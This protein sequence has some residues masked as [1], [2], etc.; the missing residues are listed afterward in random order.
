MLSLNFS[1]QKLFRWFRRP[2][3]WATSDWQLHHK[4]VLA[5]VYRHVQFFGETSNHPG[6]S[7]P[8]YPRLGI[9]WSGF[10]KNKIIFEREEISDHWCDSGKYDRAA[11]GNWIGRLCEVLRCLLWRGLSYHCPHC[12]NDWEEY[13]KRGNS[14][15]GIQIVIQKAPQ[16]TQWKAHW[17]AR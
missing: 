2:Q 9:L 3:L 7:A 14:T 15:S 13:S 6:D 17:Q 5:H 10:P 12:K 1:L 16:Y 4:N 8:L 11:D